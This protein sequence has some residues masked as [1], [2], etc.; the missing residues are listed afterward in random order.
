MAFRVGSN[1]ENQK[2][3]ARKTRERLLAPMSE[4]GHPNLQ[5][6]YIATN[7]IVSLHECDARKLDVLDLRGSRP[8]N[9]ADWAVP[10]SSTTAPT[11]LRDGTEP[12]GSAR[13]R[14][15]TLRPER[16]WSRTI[17]AINC[18]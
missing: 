6:R 4:R 8:T 7:I 12:P 17:E 2:G 15:R 13:H 16:L 10:A 1:V 5:R 14:G 11:E 18:I 3:K 9:C